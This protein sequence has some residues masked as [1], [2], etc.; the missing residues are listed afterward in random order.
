L[1]RGRGE[2]VRSREQWKVFDRMKRT[3][4]ELESNSNRSSAFSLTTSRT[5]RRLKENQRV[6]DQGLL[7][8]PQSAVAAKPIEALAS[9][10]ALALTAMRGRIA[11]Q[12]TAREIL[13]K[14][15]HSLARSL[16]E[17]LGVLC[18]FSLEIAEGSCCELRSCLCR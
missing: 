11:A 3:R 13:W 7:K 9:K 16:L 2:K 5:G 8:V 1:P 4:R 14:P 10:G 18:R 12:S 6:R 17:C 15:P